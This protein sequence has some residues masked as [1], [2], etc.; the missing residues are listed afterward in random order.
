MVFAGEQGPLYKVPV[1]GGAPEPITTLDAARGETAHRFPQF[2]PDGETFLYVALPAKSGRMTVFASD[3]HGREPVEI[4]SS[5]SS[6][7]YSEGYLIYQ[8]GRRLMAQQ[9]DTENME[10]SGEPIAIGQAPRRPPAVGAPALSASRNGRLAILNLEDLNTQL[11]WLDRSGSVMETLELESGR[12]VAPEISPD[13]KYVAL[14]KKMSPEESDIWVLELERMVMT[15]LTSGPGNHDDPV[16]APDGEYIA[17]S[18]D[19]DGPWNIYRKPFPGGGEPE[20]V[21]VGDATFKNPLDWSPD[22][23]YVLYEQI[24]TG[25]N[26]DLWIAPADGKGEQRPYLEETHQEE[27]GRFSP[28]GRWIVYVSHETGKASPYLNSFPDPGRKYRVTG[29]TGYLPDWGSDGDEIFFISGDGQRLMRASVQ[30]EPFRAGD[31]EVMIR[32]P[33]GR[34][35]AFNISPDGT[36]ILAV[37]TTRAAKPTGITVVLNWVS[38][39]PDQ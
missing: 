30:I 34:S 9:F 10:L 38:E 14:T 18:A 32:W 13:G 16:W 2:L 3:V 25:T 15:R 21:A 4:V 33:Q 31:S 36:R 1:S 37:E 24:G 39:L 20:P 5:I 12:Y 19:V 26:M 7:S 23:K 6:P 8:R 17:Y 28:D 35:P 11:V 27:Q 29:G 22:G